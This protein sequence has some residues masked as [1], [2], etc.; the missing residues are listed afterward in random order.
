MQYIVILP[1]LRNECFL[2]NELYVYIFFLFGNGAYHLIFNLI[3]FYGFNIFFK[4][5]H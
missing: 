5:K 4:I 2:S 3:Q 1:I